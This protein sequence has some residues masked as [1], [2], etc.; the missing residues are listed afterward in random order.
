[1]I[2]LDST[3]VEEEQTNRRLRRLFEKQAIRRVFHAIH[4]LHGEKAG[5]GTAYKAT[6]KLKE[7]KSSYTYSYVNQICRELLVSGGIEIFPI[8]GANP[9]QKV[10]YQPTNRGLIVFDKVIEEKRLWYENETKRIARTLDGSYPGLGAPNILDRVA[11]AFK[12]EK[13]RVAEP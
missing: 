10:A 13:E 9:R 12:A 1:M 7:E 6:K 4:V 3:G 5:D 8:D 2:G 11:R